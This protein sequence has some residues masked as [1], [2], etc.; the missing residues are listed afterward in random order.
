MDSFPCI[1]TL[2][3]CNS[4]I[5]FLKEK[6]TNL[7]SSEKK[8]LK[9]PSMKKKLKDQY[10]RSLSNYLGSEEPEIAHRWPKGLAKYQFMHVLLVLSV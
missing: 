2:K 10:L 4:C 8:K 6:H 3:S 9:D 5:I 7:K 1:T